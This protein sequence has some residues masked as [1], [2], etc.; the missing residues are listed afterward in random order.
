MNMDSSNH[1]VASGTIDE[2]EDLFLVGRFNEAL[3]RC[4]EELNQHFNFNFKSVN[5]VAVTEKSLV[6]GSIRLVSLVIQ[7][8]YELKRSNEIMPF[9]NNFY[10]GLD[11]IPFGILYMW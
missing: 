7:I 11:H 3:T 1:L 6:D 5:N 10:G 2:I 4:E 9:V 8:L